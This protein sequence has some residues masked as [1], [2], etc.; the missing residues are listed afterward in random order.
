MNMPFQRSFSQRFIL[1]LVRLGVPWL[2]LLFGGLQQSAFDGDTGQGDLVGV[3]AERLGASDGGLAGGF[4]GFGG[5]GLTGDRL[6]GFRGIP[7][8]GC[9][10]SH[11]DLGRCHHVAA[12]V[13]HYATGGERPIE[14]LLLP[15][16]VGGTV[17]GPGGNQDLGEDLIGVQGD[18]T[19][20]FVWRHDE[21]SARR[22]F[23]GT[24]GGNQFDF[25]AERDQG[26]AET[27][28]ADEVGGSAAETGVGLITAIGA[29]APAV[30]HGEEAEALAVGPAGGALAEIAAD[31]PHVA[32]LRAGDGRGGI[33]ERL[34]G[35]FDV[36]VAGEFIHGDEGA[37]AY[38]GAGL[39]D[40]FELLD[41]L[42][43]DDALGRV[44]VLLHEAEEIGAAGQH[45][46]FSPLG[47]EQR[48][49]LL[50]GRGIGVCEG[51]HQAFLPSSALSTCI[52]VMGMLGTR[53]P[54]ALATALP[55]A[56]QMP[57]A[58]GSPSP[59]T[60]RLSLT[61]RI[62]RWTTI[63]PMSLMPASL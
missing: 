1:I 59:M 11:D 39:L 44:K 12:H 16:F 2:C 7:G 27:G 62:S 24:F 9:D 60:P 28:G 35:G 22:D 42:D 48:D 36:G 31:G 15:D 56:A 25:G 10:V 47:G 61:S 50:D 37:D 3:L 21:E 26:G 63:S 19:R 58:G 43:V 34:G 53:T 4:G 57:M 38:A 32:D 14:R 6:G 41:V 54:M 18:L 55:T 17:Y 33:G 52:G 49:G 40:A 5:D 46:G 30:F 23:A 51:L 29:H 8:L 13:E 45:V 20:G